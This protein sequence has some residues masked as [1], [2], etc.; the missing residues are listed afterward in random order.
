MKGQWGPS[1]ESIFFSITPFPIA[2]AIL[3]LLYKTFLNYSGRLVGVKVQRPWHWRSYRINLHSGKRP[4]IFNKHIYRHNFQEFVSYWWICI[5]SFQELDYVQV[6]SSIT[7]SVISLQENMDL[8]PMENINTTNFYCSFLIIFQR[9]F[10]KINWEIPDVQ[11]QQTNC[12]TFHHFHSV[13]DKESNDWNF[14]CLTLWTLSWSVPNML[15]IKLGL[16]ISAFFPVVWLRWFA[17][18]FPGYPFI[19]CINIEVS[20][21]S[22]K[23]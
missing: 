19:L 6:N 15:T 12:Q 10:L 3:G 22:Q 17:I 9:F 20:C 18:F 21:C 2:V 23:P 16:L 11:P 14:F 1:P 13:F 8:F 7:S 5:W 4:R